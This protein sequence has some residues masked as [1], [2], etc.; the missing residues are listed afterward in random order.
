MDLALGI[1]GIVIAFVGVSV[2]ALGIR[3]KLA[4]PILP[5]LPGLPL[6]GRLINWLIARA[7]WILVGSPGA[8]GFKL[9]FVFGL[10]T[11]A[12]VIGMVGAIIFLPSALCEDGPDVRVLSPSDGEAV[13][14]EIFVEGK[15]RERGDDEFLVVFVRPLPDDPFQ[16]Y[17]SQSIPQQIDEHRWHARPVYVGVP[18]DQPGTPFKVCAVITRSQ[19]SPGERFR[20]LPAG[21]SDCVSVTRE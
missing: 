5:T 17:H 13:P 19:I 14:H 16:D 20:M 10:G 18:D 9:G 3:V 21:P 4:R 15:A 8:Q 12:T 6:I 1:G 11:A 7:Q 2:N